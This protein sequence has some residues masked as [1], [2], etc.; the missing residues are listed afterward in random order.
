ML[1]PI[2]VRGYLAIFNTRE[3][4]DKYV[5][6]KLSARKIIENNG[7]RDIPLVVSHVHFRVDLTIGRVT[8]LHVDNTGLFCEGIIDNVAFLNVHNLLNEDF[9]KYFSDAASRQF[10]YLKCFLPCFSLSHF[11]ETF[12][13]RHVA[14][15]DLGARRGTLVQYSFTERIQ[16]KA[17]SSNE[18]DFFSVLNCYSRNSLKLPERNN[19]LFRDALLCGETDTE[20]INA[21]HDIQKI[22]I[23]G[24]QLET[25]K[26]QQFTN[27]EDALKFITT[28][29]RAFEESGKKRSRESDSEP[30][31]KR[32][33]VEDGVTNAYQT[34]EQ[35][36]RQADEKGGKDDFKDFKKEMLNLHAEL[37]NSQKKMLTEMFES[38]QQSNV[39]ETNTIQLEQQRNS[40]ANPYQTT[41]GNSSNQP[42]SQMTSLAKPF[43]QLPPAFQEPPQGTST[44]QS[45]Q[46]D[47]SVQKTS[48]EQ[49]TIVPKIVE[50][51][52]EE[53]LIDA[54]MQ[55]NT[56]EKLVNELFRIFILKLLGKER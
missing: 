11:K 1:P 51:T 4:D 8:K 44:Q 40:L 43:Q 37:I 49:T 50:K 17:Y 47:T 55:V 54:G 29:A 23:K 19:L 42:C 33:R 2:Q 3:S 22:N 53:V 13:I 6:T 14:L 39:D 26:K 27:M 45:T 24:N 20:F 5:L 18:N 31:P 38:R 28:I 48:L 46:H 21:S 15:V 56:Q 12:Q 36:N 30:V 16:P 41:L 32:A 25:K 9:I 7:N 10:L 52:A 34:F 35:L